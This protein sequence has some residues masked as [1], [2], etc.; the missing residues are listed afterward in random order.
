KV[1]NYGVTYLITE[2]IRMAFCHRFRCKDKVS[3]HIFDLF[4]IF[5]VPSFTNSGT[6]ALPPITTP[7]NMVIG[8]I[9]RRFLSP[10]TT[11]ASSWTAKE[12]PRAILRYLFGG[13]FSLP[14][15]LCVSER[16]LTAWRSCPVVSLKNAMVLAF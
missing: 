10:G 3:F 7:S 4:G 5:F 2:L 14:N 9:P 6:I 13:S 15:M 1:V 11:I 8:A 12:P 16:Q